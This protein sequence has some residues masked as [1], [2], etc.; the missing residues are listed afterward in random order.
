M[1]D[2]SA[3]LAKT[4]QGG[5]GRGRANFTSQSKG[6]ST[7][8]GRGRNTNK[9]SR[10]CD[11]CHAPGHVRETCFQLNGY[12]EWYQQLKTQKESINLAKPE[13]SKTP[14]DAS[15]EATTKQGA[16]NSILQNL[17]QELDKIKGKIGN[18][19]HTVNLAHMSNFTGNI[20]KP[21]EGEFAGIFS[22]LQ[23]IITALNASFKTLE[24][25]KPNSWVIDTGATTHMCA[26][27][28]YFTKFHKA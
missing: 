6:R 22:S 25:I 13:T 10:Y 27:S 14:F 28:D 4:Q 15:E 3:F 24:N 20:P 23:N 26:N 16:Y 9:S 19:T 18:D 21:M 17:Q 2:N 12:P 7:G 5:Y 1:Q 11:Y 8:R